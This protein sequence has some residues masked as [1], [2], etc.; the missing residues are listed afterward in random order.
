MY[1]IIFAYMMLERESD[2]GGE[3]VACLPQ[4][5]S[6]AEMGWDL[7]MQREVHCG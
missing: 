1:F 5:S 3:N 2:N 4:C 7:Y 6:F